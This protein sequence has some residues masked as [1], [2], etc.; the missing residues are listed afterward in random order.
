[1]CISS[2]SLFTIGYTVTNVSQG[3][4]SVRVFSSLKFLSAILH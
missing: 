2:Y 4:C 3:D 1:M